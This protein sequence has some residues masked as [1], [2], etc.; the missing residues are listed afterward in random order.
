MHA[1]DQFMFKADG[2]ARVQSV[3]I[4][5]ADR[6][7]MEGLMPAYIATRSPPRWTV[8]PGR[9]YGSPFGTALANGH[10]QVS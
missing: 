4:A 6:Q 5:V 8:I 7:H 3:A 9:C 2:E 1:I 10:V